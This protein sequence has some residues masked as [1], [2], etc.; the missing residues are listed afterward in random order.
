MELVDMP[1]SPDTQTKI[2]LTHKHNNKA[3]S[4]PRFKPHDRLD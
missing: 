3:T 2:Q 1:T 4:T